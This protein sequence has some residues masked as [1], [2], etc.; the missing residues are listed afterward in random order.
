[1]ILELADIRIHPGQ[2]AAFDEAIAHALTTVITQ[3]KGFKGYSIHT[4]IENPERY[5]LQI[6]WETLENHTVDFRGSAAF[7]NWR[8][9]V[10]PF[11]ATPPTVEHFQ[12]GV[13]SD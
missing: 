1:M 7:A 13:N 4:G 5:L 12:M 9:I 8:A 10:G 6:Q 11:F 3:A 2:Q